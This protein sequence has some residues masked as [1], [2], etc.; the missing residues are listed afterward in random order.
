MVKKKIAFEFFFVSSS[1]HFSMSTHVGKLKPRRLKSSQTPLPYDDDSR[2]A[3]R[4]EETAGANI[5]GLIL[6]YNYFFLSIPR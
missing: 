3:A 4:I 2:A 1:A 5:S 6:V